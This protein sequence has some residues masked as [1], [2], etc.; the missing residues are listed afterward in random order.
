MKD[1]EE[2]LEHL[3][4]REKKWIRRCSEIKEGLVAEVDQPR[5]SH[6]RAT[7]E[8]EPRQDQD[9][10]DQDHRGHVENDQTHALALHGGLMAAPIQPQQA[11]QRDGREF[12]RP[13]RRP[14]CQGS[15]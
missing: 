7:G 13:L 12:Q 2:K 9:R 8:R 4:V 11:T 5:K 14:T 10:Q 1:A 15:R 6:K 3:K